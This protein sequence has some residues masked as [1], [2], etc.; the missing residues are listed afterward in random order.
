MSLHIS[1]VANTLYAHKEP[2]R[3]RLNNAS[4]ACEELKLYVLENQFQFMRVEC[5]DAVLA[6][7]KDEHGIEEWINAKGNLINGEL[8]IG[9]LSALASASGNEWNHLEMLC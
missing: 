7:S 6:D 2:T 8:L 1:R 4:K 3:P 5:R 9:R